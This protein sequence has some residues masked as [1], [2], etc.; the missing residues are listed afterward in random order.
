M[1]QIAQ[2]SGGQTYTAATVEQ[3]N[4]SYESVQKQIGFQV[5]PGPASEG[6]LRMAV[7]VATIAAC[8]ALAINRRLPT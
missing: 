4:Q 3:L 8:L 2:L 6:W 1:T 5:L 7:F